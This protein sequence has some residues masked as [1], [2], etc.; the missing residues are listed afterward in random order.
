MAFVDASLAQPGAKL[1][2]D[3]RG[4]LVPATVEP[5]PFFKR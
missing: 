1:E 5:L 3:L 2:V 4:T